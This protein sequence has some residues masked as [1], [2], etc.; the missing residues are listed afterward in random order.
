MAISGGGTRAVD[1]VTGMPLLYDPS[2]LYAHNVSSVI[3]ALRGTIFRKDTS[4]RTVFY[5]R[6]LNNAVARYL[7]LTTHRRFNLHAAALFP[8]VPSYRKLVIEEMIRLVARYLSGYTEYVS[9]STS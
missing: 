3:G 4:M 6:S 9:I 2:S 8:D 5:V 1:S 7:E